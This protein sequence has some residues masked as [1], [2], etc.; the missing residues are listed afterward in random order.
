MTTKILQLIIQRIQLQI[1]ILQLR[2]RIKWFD[3]KLTI[4]NLKKSHLLILHHGG[5]NWSFYQ[6]NNHHKNLW[7]F[8]SS[9]GFYIGYQK[10]IASDGKLFIA[11]RDNEE[12]AHTVDPNRPGHYNKNSVGIC[13]QGNFEIERPT[14]AQLRTLKIEL[15]DYRARGFEIKM[16]KDFSQTLCPGKNL[17]AWLENYKKSK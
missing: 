8:C 7:G 14:D 11:R 17:I 13:L 16:H 1:Q 2:I 6:V 5:G 10:W 12:G 4:P 15:D 3:E 9:L